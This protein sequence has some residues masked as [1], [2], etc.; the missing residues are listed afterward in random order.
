MPNNTSVSQT[1]TGVFHS[2]CFEMLSL[3]FINTI[4][5]ALLIFKT[6]GKF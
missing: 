2:Y 5:L 3:E 1:Q 6:F 4:N